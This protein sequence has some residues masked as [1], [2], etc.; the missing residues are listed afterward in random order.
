MASEIGTTPAL[1]ASFSA[2]ASVFQSIASVPPQRGN[3]TKRVETER[4][5]A[6]EHP[7]PFGIGGSED[8]PCTSDIGYRISAIGYRTA[9]PLLY[10]VARK[11]LLPLPDVLHLALQLELL[12]RRRRWRRR[13]VRRDP[14]V[15]VILEARPRRNQPAH[16]HVLFQAAEVIHLARN[17]RF[18][19]HARR[20]LE[21]RGRDERVGR[22]RRLRD[23]EQQRTARPRTP[24]MPHHAR[25]LSQ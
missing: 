13:L 22:E 3:Y 11:R 19:E 10:F 17:R 20:L 5:V 21:R 9:K 4:A 12:G 8:P 23:A 18:G 1:T 7:R 16:R 15:P 25:V 2:S 6:P 14:H 24:A